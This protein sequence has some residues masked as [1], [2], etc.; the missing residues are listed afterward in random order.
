[1]KLLFNVGA[2]AALTSISTNSVHAHEFLLR[3]AGGEVIVS[4]EFDKFSPV[5]H[6]QAISTPIRSRILSNCCY[7]LITPQKGR[8]CH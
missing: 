3:G 6:P 1:M 8:G 7:H 4:S 2:L 5:C